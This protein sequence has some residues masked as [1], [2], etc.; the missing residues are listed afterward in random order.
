MTVA[1]DPALIDLAM[2]LADASGPIALN[3][4]RTD[5]AVERKDDA[6]PVTRADRE[7]EDV[8][9]QLLIAE[10]P[11]QGIL[12]EEHGSERLD[13]EYVWSITPNTGTPLRVSAIR[14]PNSGIPL[15]KARVL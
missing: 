10:A 14:V 8:L 11:D 2:R 7:A 4:F 1:V 9:R 12:G 6:S 13:A 3:Y 5:T 15:M